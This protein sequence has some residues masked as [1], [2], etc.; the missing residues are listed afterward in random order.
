MISHCLARTFLTRALLTAENQSK[1]EQILTDEGCGAADGCSVNMT[2]LGQE[3]DRLFS[4]IEMGPVV[5]LQNRSQLNI[6]TASPGEFII[7]C[8]T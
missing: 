6:F 3:G 7:H 5:D 2:F 4:N 1:V 8:N